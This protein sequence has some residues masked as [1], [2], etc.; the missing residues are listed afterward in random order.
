MNTEKQDDQN[1]QLFTEFS[2]ENITNPKSL[3]EIATESTSKLSAAIPHDLN[4]TKT[5]TPKYLKSRDKIMDEDSNESFAIRPAYR[6]LNMND[7][8][9]ADISLG[10]LTNGLCNL[11]L[12]DSQSNNLTLSDDEFV[13]CQ[14]FSNVSNYPRTQQSDVVASLDSTA[15]T[16]DFTKSAVESNLNVTAPVVAPDSFRFAQ[17]NRVNESYS[18]DAS[19]DDHSMMNINDTTRNVDDLKDMERIMS[20]NASACQDNVNINKTQEHG[21][22]GTIND[23][24]TKFPQELQHS[25]TEQST[26]NDVQTESNVNI[27]NPNDTFEQEVIQVDTQE[28]SQENLTVDS[29]VIP[30]IEVQQATPVKDVKNVIQ[31]EVK[32][33]SFSSVIEDIGIKIKQEL[34]EEMDVDYDEQDQKVISYM[35][36]QAQVTPT[37]GLKFPFTR[38]NEISFGHHSPSTE[39]HIESN[40]EEEFKMAQQ[41]GAPA[42]EHVLN[43]DES[44]N[45]DELVNMFNNTFEHEKVKDAVALNEGPSTMTPVVV[46]GNKGKQ[47]N[48]MDA[49]ENN[50]D[51]QFK[52]PSVPSVQSRKSAD[53]FS[54]FNGMDVF[55]GQKGSM[56]QKDEVFKPASSTFQFAET[57]FDFLQN[58]EDSSKTWDDD[59]RNSIL[60]KFDPLLRK[61]VP[62][63]SEQLCNRLSGTREEDDELID[64]AGMN[65]TQTIEFETKHNHK[66]QSFNNTIKEESMV[67]TESLIIPL[68]N[69]DAMKDLINSTGV[70]VNIDVNHYECADIKIKTRFQQGHKIVEMENRIKNEVLKSEDSEN[71]LKESEMRE[72]GLLKR[73]TEKDKIINKMSGVVEAYEK[74]IAELIAEKEQLVLKSEKKCS[75]LK[76]DGEMNAQHL[77]SLETTFSDLH[78]KYERTKQLAAEQKER[79]EVILQEKKLNAD[80]LKMQEM[81]YEK[82]K[83]HAMT[84]L[85]IANTKLSDLTRNH[86]A[87][88][89]KLRAQLKKE[90]ISRA[91]MSEQLLQKTKENAELVKICDELINGQS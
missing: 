46:A 59:P 72:E 90:E 54:N 78:A 48:F 55:A 5:S 2:K 20:D 19:Q 37:K 61:P 39:D 84:Q 28:S 91:S 33:E 13:E 21:D 17:H 57:D 30:T 34:D 74:A 75:D 22:I 86:S 60:L 56:D 7:S 68:N 35:A 47:M 82:M 65:S 81:R 12:D 58:R 41:N 15:K 88:L 87:E 49:I 69:V 70:D 24:E 27:I 36:S 25:I 3:T 10:F 45:K 67:D 26:Q 42:D 89:T 83:I 79:E 50:F 80:N 44:C 6:Q 1:N 14:S 85:E 18:L 73:I 29:L 32:N 77:A 16:F 64:I 66:H 43:G 51:V 9:K 8:Q 53:L 4:I 11:G 38:L 31:E 76:H 52:M 62:V 40:F 71:K 63:F 23:I